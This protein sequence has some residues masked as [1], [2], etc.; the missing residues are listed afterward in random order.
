MTIT[1]YEKAKE[2]ITKSESTANKARG[3]LERL[4]SELKNNHGISSEEEAQEYLE[5]LETT[6]ERDL[7]K[8]KVLA[9]ELEEAVDWNSL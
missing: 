9:Q 7:A 4:Y 6:K 3:A 2:I 8:R 5:K 1:E